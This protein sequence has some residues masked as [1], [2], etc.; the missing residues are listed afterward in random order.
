M[1]VTD[2][3]GTV[4]TFNYDAATERITSMVADSANLGGSS[5]LALTTYYGH[6]STGNVTSVTDPRGHVTT[7]TYDK[8][9]RPV[10]TTLPATTAGT[11]VTTLTYDDDGRVI[12][13]TRSSGGS[14]IVTSATY[15]PSGKTLTTTDAR[16]NVTTFAYDVLDSGFWRA[17]HDGNFGQPVIERSGATC[18]RGRLPHPPSVPGCR[19][20]P[21]ARPT[22]A[23]ASG[24]SE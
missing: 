12:Q 21:P 1:T 24:R 11:I 22:T 3:V 23:P 14:S 4:T 6:D 20:P 7:T 15:S 18:S 5:P 10:T 17:E 19:R 8:L 13:T 16:N 9:R 2:P